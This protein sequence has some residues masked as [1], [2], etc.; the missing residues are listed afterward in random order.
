MQ[1]GNGGA[2]L[3]FAA[4]GP[5]TA[6]AHLY[7]HDPCRVL[8]PRPER[9]DPFTAVLLTTS[10]GLTGGDRVRIA[11]SARDGTTTSVTSQ[12][13]EKIYRA[14]GP[15][16]DIGIDIRVDRAWLEW[17]PQETILFNHAKLRRITKV[18]VAAGGRFLGAEMVV[19][20]RAARGERYDSGALYDRW[21]I[22]RDGKLAWI[23]ALKLDGDIAG[24]LA[25]RWAF[26]AAGAMASA[27]YVGDDA[28]QH[29]DAARELTEAA[30]G[31]AAV[32]VV[33]G[34]L[35][36]RF[37]HREAAV[38]RQDLMAYL[39]G[40]RHVAGGLPARLPRCWYH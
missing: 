7:Q 6:L 23:D 40:L 2:E 4:R 1:R 17:L 5:E 22:R 3:V 14:L 16:C 24:S 38:V 39:C 12:A 18:D 13:A 35:V 25:S 32:T 29:L 21:E 26:D 31:H 36:A 8:F 27:M 11:M 30:A 33:N 20:G 9:G 19:F 37:L 34:L 15:A 10:G 28:G